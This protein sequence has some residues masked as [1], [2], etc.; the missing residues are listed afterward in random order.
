M[1]PLAT[2]IDAVIAGRTV[3]SMFAAT[4]AARPDAVAL[5]WRPAGSETASGAL[6]W[7]EYA[8]R[9]CRIAAGLR[10]LGISPGQRVVLMMRNRPEFH[11]ADMGVLLAGGTPVSIYNS[12][13][14]DRI[15][16]VVDHAEARV[17]IVEDAFAQRFRAARA[18]LS[19]VEKV[20]VVGPAGG[21]PAAAAPDG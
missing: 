12:S 10:D 13:P 9:A 17:A 8:D 15:A 19:G 11:A 2:D 3:P 1:G 6:T 14:P 4:V 21:G 5:R 18:L 20:V 16:H 7:A